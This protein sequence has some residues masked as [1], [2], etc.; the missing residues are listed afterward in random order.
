MR[1]KALCMAFVH[2][3]NI[4]ND[5]TVITIGI[6]E[7][8]SGP[9][10]CSHTPN[11]IAHA[12]GVLHPTWLRINDVFFTH[13]LSTCKSVCPGRGLR[14]RRNLVFTGGVDVGKLTFG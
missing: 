4:R 6:D 14:K 11:R 1:L 2:S 13:A 5:T 9:W 12:G 10:P 8:F 7:N 3:H